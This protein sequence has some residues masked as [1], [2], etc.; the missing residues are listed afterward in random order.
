MV[1]AI[2]PLGGIEGCQNDSLQCPQWW[3][4]TQHYDFKLNQCL[5]LGHGKVITSNVI[6]WF[7]ITPSMTLLLQLKARHIYALQY[8]VSITQMIQRHI[9]INDKIFCTACTEYGEGCQ[10]QFMGGGGG[11]GGGGGSI[12]KFLFRGVNITKCHIK[13]DSS[14]SPSQS[15]GKN[16]TQTALTHCGLEM[17]YGDMD[18]GQHCL[19]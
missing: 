9:N 13:H 2:S 10:L 8:N 16:I 15:C 11:G 1:T 17:L 7:V 3:Y 14:S 4:S 5:S 18:L 6:W 19:S 12:W